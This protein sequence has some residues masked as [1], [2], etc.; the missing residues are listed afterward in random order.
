MRANPMREF[1]RVAVLLAVVPLVAACAGSAPSNT[2]DPYDVPAGEYLNAEQYQELS[3]DEAI[4]YCRQ[5]AAEL[6]IL[7]DNAAAAEQ[8]LPQLE[9]EVAALEAKI[10]GMGEDNMALDAELAA[11]EARLEALRAL[12]TTYTVLPNDWLR[13]ISAQTQ[14]YGTEDEWRKLY[15]GNRDQITDPNLIFPGQVLRVP[16][17]EEGHAMAGTVWTVKGGETLRII[18]E[19]VYGSRAESYRI[20]QANQDVISHPDFILPGMQLQIP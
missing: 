7:N 20:F 13:K 18:A 16:R 2:S 19:S 5:L 3:A 12:P 14:I 11:L 1:L 6:D 9:A 10:S 15:N 8:M 4:E 17:H